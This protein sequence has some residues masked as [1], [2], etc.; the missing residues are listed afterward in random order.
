MRV[1]SKKK[2]SDFVALHPE[3]RSS[4]ESWYRIVTA[5]SL[6]SLVELRKTF[7]HA[8]SVGTPVFDIAPTW[9][10]TRN[11]SQRWTHLSM[12]LAAMRIIY[13]GPQRLDIDLSYLV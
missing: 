4:Q 10:V 7:P 6:G 11:L 8:G 12:R 3:S 5:S 1:I 13:D 9:R 2:V